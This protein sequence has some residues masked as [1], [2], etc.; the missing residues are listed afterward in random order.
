MKSFSESINPAD[1][2]GDP[3]LVVLDASPLLHQFWHIKSDGPDV[4]ERFL[5]RIDRIRDKLMHMIKKPLFCVCSFDNG[6]A[7]FRKWIFEGYKSG[8][9]YDSDLAETIEHA[10]E[11]LVNSVN[12]CR[13]IAPYGFESDDVL[14]TLAT[15][16]E[17]NVVLHT[18]DKDAHQLLEHG[19]VTIIKKSNV[20]MQT[21]EVDFEF[22]T[23]S[24]FEKD[25]GFAP[26]RFTEYQ[27]LAGDSADTITGAVGIGDKTAKRLLRAFDG[28]I[29]TWELE[30]AEWLSEKQ[31][32]ALREVVPKLYHLRHLFNGVRDLDF[33]LE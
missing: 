8:R 20:N 16:Y 6:K 2:E 31:I 1:V 13:A 32:E 18:I 26:C 17:G 27:C 33:K 29:E 24:Q 11:A 5:L 19:R 30:T 7:T 4:V 10:K 15:Q 28:P 25:Y 9:T 14:A 12:W 22:Y 21:K 23:A 3:V